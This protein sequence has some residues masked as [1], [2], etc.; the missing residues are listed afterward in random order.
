MVFVHMGNNASFD[1]L[2]IHLW[3]RIGSHVGYFESEIA[4]QRRRH[5]ESKVMMSFD[6][7]ESAEVSTLQ[8]EK[9]HAAAHI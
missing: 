5:K 4:P 6:R 9:L 8:L 1:C 2:I 7:A 3:L